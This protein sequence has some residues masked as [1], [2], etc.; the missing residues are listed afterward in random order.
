MSRSARSGGWRNDAAYP[1]KLQQ[2]GGEAK[3]SYVGWD[4]GWWVAL[5]GD[6]WHRRFWIL[7]HGFNWSKDYKCWVMAVKDEEKAEQLRAFMESECKG[8]MKAYKGEGIFNGLPEIPLFEFKGSGEES[9]KRWTSV[10][11]AFRKVMRAKK[12]KGELPMQEEVLAKGYLAVM[13][14]PRARVG[15]KSR[16][17]TDLGKLFGAVK[18]D[19]ERK[20][21]AEEKAAELEGK[22]LDELFEEAQE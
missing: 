10:V 14:D 9:A 18:S 8:R 2:G 5:V 16:A 3:P 19:S 7:Q 1:R 15:E 22:S 6:T 17:L 13:E 4:G 12:R 20:R 21:E 11:R